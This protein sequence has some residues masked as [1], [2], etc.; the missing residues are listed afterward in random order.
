MFPCRLFTHPVCVVLGGLQTEDGDDVSWTDF[1]QP[2]RDTAPESMQPVV[3]GYGKEAET[4]AAEA[5]EVRPRC[6]Y[7]AQPV[8]HR[9]MRPCYPLH[10]LP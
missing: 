10:L 7:D 4:D 9:L 6:A 8:C 5:M 3:P 1:L 2:F